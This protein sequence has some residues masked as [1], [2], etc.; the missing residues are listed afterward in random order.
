MQLGA[1]I[2]DAS[3]GGCLAA[4]QGKCFLQSYV[5]MVMR[6]HEMSILGMTRTRPQ[7]TK[8]EYTHVMAV[9]EDRIK[10]FRQ[11]SFV[12]FQALENV[13]RLTPVPELLGKTK[14]PQKAATSNCMPY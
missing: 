3:Y 7:K 11:A 6:L 8:T 13:C 14:A 2:P 1:C 4:L 10:L 9:L 12:G 5:K